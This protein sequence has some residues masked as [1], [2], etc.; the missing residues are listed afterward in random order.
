MNSPNV[1]VSELA[2]NIINSRCPF[3]ALG[4]EEAEHNL[5]DVKSA[6]RRL[7]LLFHPDKSTLPVQLA[8]EVFQALQRAYTD[9][10]Q[11][12]KQFNHSCASNKNIWRQFYAEPAMPQD[13]GFQAVPTHTAGRTP[14]PPQRCHQVCAWP[15]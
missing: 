3:T 7:C 4:L 8:L 12:L 15:G 11:D 6:Y 2:A 10:T 5:S 13:P 1:P 14:Q 9:A